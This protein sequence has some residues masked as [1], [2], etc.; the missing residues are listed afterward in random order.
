MRRQLQQPIRGY[1]YPAGSRKK[2]DHWVSSGTLAEPVGGNAENGS[3]YQGSTEA[4]AEVASAKLGG[5]YLAFRGT[6]VPLTRAIGVGTAGPISESEI[7]QVETFFRSRHAPVS[8]LISER[9]HP[10]LENQLA[11]RGYDSNDYLQ[12]SGLDLGIAPIHAM[13]SG[14]EGTPVTASEWDL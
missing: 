1:E 2:L 10:G 5:S 3:D 7:T 13:P 4:V 8:I 12:N 6:D 11:A 14:L 9:T